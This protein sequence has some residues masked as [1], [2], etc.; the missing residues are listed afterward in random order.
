MTLS[1]LP[2]LGVSFSISKIPTVENSAAYAHS[3]SP[4]LCK[5]P[6]GFP[7][8]SLCP[9]GF[10]LHHHHRAPAWELGVSSEPNLGE[11]GD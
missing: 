1:V 3:H 7:L 11:W 8:I 5:Q 4:F 2:S 9:C 6:F 10:T